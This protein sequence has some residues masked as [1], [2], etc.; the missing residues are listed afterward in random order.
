MLHLC[1]IQICA[2]PLFHDENYLVHVSHVRG[3]ELYILTVECMSIPRNTCIN[4][5]RAGI[6]YCL[7][8][9]LRSGCAK[10]N[11]TIVKNSKNV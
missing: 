1:Y 2:G 9:N 4:L 8:V 11:T 10:K 7:N 3:N 5:S 6:Q